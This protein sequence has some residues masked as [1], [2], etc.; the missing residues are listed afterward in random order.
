MFLSN[1]LLLA[2][3]WDKYPGHPNLVP[4]Y[5]GHRGDL[6]NWVRKPIFGREG[7]GVE[8]YAPDYNV[9]VKPEE[10][11]FFSTAPESEFVY[12]EYIPAPRYEG[13][14]Q[15]VSHPVLGVWVVGGRCVGVGIRESNGALTDYWCRF[16]PHLVDLNAPGS[17]GSASQ[18]PGTANFGY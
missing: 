7:D 4:T 1:K 14:I 5:A 12:Q 6:R 18:H 16:A 8:I 17:L 3:L 13:I 11:D 9:F 10:D 15:P 2:A